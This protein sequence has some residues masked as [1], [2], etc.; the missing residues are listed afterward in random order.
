MVFVSDLSTLPR[1][2]WILTFKL[3]LTDLHLCMEVHQRYTFKPRFQIQHK[4]CLNLRSKKTHPSIHITWKVT[5][6]LLY[7]I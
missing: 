7:Q 4:L 2:D 5:L 3:N 1:T 6:F